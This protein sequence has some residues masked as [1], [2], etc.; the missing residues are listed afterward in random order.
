MDS[1]EILTLDAGGDSNRAYVVLPPGRDE[2]WCVAPSYAARPILAACRR[3][4]RRLTWIL[5]THTHQDHVAGV[6]EVRAVFPCPV[7]VH[8]AE[9]R[10]V[11]GARAIPGDGPLPEPREVEVFH[12]PG[13]T[14]GGVC[15]RIGGHLFTGDTLFVDWVGR[16]DLPG[17]D[18]AALFRSL[19]RLRELPGDL[20]LHPGH[21]YGS[22]PSRTLGEE[23]LV[24]P[25]L[26]ARDFAEFLRR[27]PELTD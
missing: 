7:W 23:V 22:V 2:A 24:N 27:L 14:P 16:A 13:H 1:I 19:Q 26:G 6:E 17:G 10:S 20:V 3:R 18:P 21:H 12:T 15:Y 8:P 25:F 9:T 11:A 5:L 4:Q